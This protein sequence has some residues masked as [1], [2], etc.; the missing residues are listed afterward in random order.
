MAQNK[1]TGGINSYLKNKAVD[2]KEEDIAKNPSAYSLMA[3]LVTSR[4]T[5]SFQNNGE[6]SDYSPNL[7]YLLGISSEKAQEIDDNEAIMQLLPDLERGAQILISYILSP[8]YLL[9][10]ELQYRPPAGIF[11]QSVGQN[12]VDVVKRYIFD[13]CF[14]SR[15][16]S[17]ISTVLSRNSAKN[18]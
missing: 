2:L 1:F 3:K 9:K 18:N 17:S 6:L 8:K 15:S 4:S 10:P 12:M 5:D 16:Y 11:T 7:D 13:I 14:D